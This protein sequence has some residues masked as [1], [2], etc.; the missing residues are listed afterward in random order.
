[1]LGE[2]VEV[3]LGTESPTNHE[4][5]I[6]AAPGKGRSCTQKP[7]C[8][9]ENVEKMQGLFTKEEGQGIAGAWTNAGKQRLKTG[10]LR[11]KIKG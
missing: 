3:G 2:G 10:R 9:R 4:S 11:G 6:T 1:M 5:D 8:P 7:K